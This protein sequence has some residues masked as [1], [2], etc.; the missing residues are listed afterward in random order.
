MPET[1]KQSELRP[2]AVVWQRLVKAG[3]TRERCGS[4]HPQTFEAILQHLLAKAALIVAVGMI[5]GA[6][7]DAGPARCCARACAKGCE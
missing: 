2:L 4:T 1:M 6:R 5:E 7:S 3:A